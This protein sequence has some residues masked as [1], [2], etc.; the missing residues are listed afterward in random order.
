MARCA[1][2]LLFGPSTSH[3]F[4]AA[5]A[6]LGIIAVASWRALQVDCAGALRAVDAHLTCCV[7]TRRARAYW[8]AQRGCRWWR[9]PPISKCHIDEKDVVIGLILMPV[10]RQLASTDAR[11]GSIG[12]CTGTWFTVLATPDMFGYGK[13]LQPIYT[14]MCPLA[15]AFADQRV[16]AKMLQPRYSAFITLTVLTHPYLVK[17][18]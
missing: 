7:L 9:M 5:Q 11:V 13:R 10:D 4:G 6:S 12:I 1:L 16:D 17:L 2:F 3:W 14:F 18:R 15:A 8:A